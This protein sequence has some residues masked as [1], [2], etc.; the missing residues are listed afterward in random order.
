MKPISRSAGR[1]AVASAAYR[2]GEKL[3]D[4]RQGLTFDYSRKERI[5]ETGIVVPQGSPEVSRQELWGSVELHHKRGDAVTAREIEIAL[6]HEISKDDRCRMVKDF[7]EYIAENYGVAVDYSIHT[8]SSE[9]NHHAHMMLTT[10]SY[11]PD[12]LGKKV[13]ELDPIACDKMRCTNAA[14]EL[15]ADWASLANEYLVA[16]KVPTIDHRS[17]KDRGIEYEP[18]RHVGLG[19]GREEV[20]AYNENIKAE[21]DLDRTMQELDRMALELEKI[22]RELTQIISTQDQSPIAKPE[23]DYVTQLDELLGRLNERTGNE[24]SGAGK[25]YGQGDFG[26]ESDAGAGESNRAFSSESNLAASLSIIDR[27][28]NQKRIDRNRKLGLEPEADQPVPEPVGNNS[29]GT[30]DQQ[31]HDESNRGR[32]NTIS[33]EEAKRVEQE[34][35]AGIDKAEREKL[36]R[37]EQ[38]N[39]PRYRGVQR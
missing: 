21:R 37:D 33:A 16:S 15:R 38:E 34:L 4:P 10:V 8:S 1:S 12:G 23:P 32:G 7:A 29:A 39:K 13:N 2:S 19:S 36:E 30:Q 20:I 14:D 27:E 5:V 24:S 31:R 26:F 18:M 25:D 9:K 6:P 17:F 28:L 35:R 3:E 22:E 11:G